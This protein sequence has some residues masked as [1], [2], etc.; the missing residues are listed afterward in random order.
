MRPHW[1]RLT[2]SAWRSTSPLAENGVVVGNKTP[3]NFCTSSAIANQF[4]FDEMEVQRCI[5]VQRCVSSKGAYGAN[6]LNRAKRVSRSKVKPK[7]PR[8]SCSLISSVR[9][10]KVIENGILIPL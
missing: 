8:T 4:L 6:D 1:S 3:F 7:F 2:A 5:I 9:F 10:A